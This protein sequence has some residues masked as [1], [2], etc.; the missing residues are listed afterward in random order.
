MQRD[1]ALPRHLPTIAIPTGRPIS[2]SRYG[3]TDGRDES[4]ICDAR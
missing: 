1:R 4:A 3:P 2:T